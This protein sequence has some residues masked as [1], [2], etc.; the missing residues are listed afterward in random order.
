MGG[1]VGGGT[2]PC[3]CEQTSCSSLCPQTHLCVGLAHCHAVGQQRW[4]SLANKASHNEGL[5]QAEEQT[6]NDINLRGAG[7]EQED[8][9][10]KCCDKLG[11]RTSNACSSPAS[12]PPNRGN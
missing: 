12:A 4:I 7:D 8:G 11:D 1:W 10:A 5:Q 6:L 2:V 9:G 3:R